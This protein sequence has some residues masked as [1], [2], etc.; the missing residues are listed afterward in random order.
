MPDLHHADVAEPG[1]LPALL[2]AAVAE[3]V[4]HAAD[5]AV[6]GLVEQFRFAATR[7]GQPMRVAVVG[8]I[9]AGKSTMI[10]ALIGEDVVPSDLREATYNVNVFRH[11][12]T[13]GIR[14][15][16]KD[17]ARPPLDAPIADLSAVT[18]RD[19]S[20]A[21]ELDAIRHVIVYHPAPMLRQF[22]L[23]DTPG[24]E[25]VYETDSDN[26]D[27]FLR[28]QVELA[29]E[30][31]AEEAAGADA[32]LYLFAHSV[33]DADAGVLQ[34]FVG[35]SVGDPTPVNAIGV[36]TKV[37]VRWRTDDPMA[38]GG[39]SARLIAEHADARRLFYTVRPACGQLAAAAQT[40]TADDLSTLRRLAALPAERFARL[41]KDAARFRRPADDLH[42]D[43][44]ARGRLLDRLGLFGVDR[45]VTMLRDSPALDDPQL[46]RALL[47]YSGVPA[48]REL[49]FAHFGRRAAAIKASAA[50]TQ[51]MA[52]C[53]R[54]R[55]SASPDARPALARVAD[56]LE[57][58]QS[59]NPAIAELAVLRD[60]YDGRLR[61][62]P[63]RT[64]E[65]LAVTGEFGDAP[66]ARLDL[67]SATPPA[68]LLEA[69]VARAAAWRTL[70]DRA[71]A[72]DRHLARGAAVVARSFE[73]LA[74]RIRTD[75]VSIAEPNA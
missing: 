19:A 18:L 71:A 28:R 35:G 45:A 31:T 7:I 40:L 51:L 58:L 46:C 42:V 25:S 11:R 33:N 59:G 3:L 17:P 37:D 64:R 44:A 27:A 26:T 55:A 12:D 21:D 66:A 72:L 43:P 8:M 10:N 41:T 22:E 74:H 63:R 65:L 56:R 30:R 23:V 60:H 48:L 68:Q 49:L 32:V 67:P 75:G 36:L 5:A 4:P 29:G 61:L 53:L 13:P 2:D 9:K 34:K 1:D 70:A 14:V 52:A 54:A 73:R 69:A 39:R 50:A 6:A 15:I 38:S 20:R 24:T 62:D 16:Y 57:R 47:E